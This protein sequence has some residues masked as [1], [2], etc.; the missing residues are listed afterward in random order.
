MHWKTVLKNPKN[1]KEM[2]TMKT[3]ELENKEIGVLLQILNTT[4]IQGAENI[5]VFMEIWD[6]LISVYEPTTNIED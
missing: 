4:Q 1:P 6:K 5:K 3:I 2:K